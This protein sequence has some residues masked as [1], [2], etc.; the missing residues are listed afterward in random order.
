MTSR[1]SLSMGAKNPIRN[2]TPIARAYIRTVRKRG[3]MGCVE[4]VPQHR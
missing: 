3:Y 1:H 2:A 4:D